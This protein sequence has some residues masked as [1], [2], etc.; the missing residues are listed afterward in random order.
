MPPATP[1]T[2]EATVPR[3]STPM[4]VIAS[5]VPV[6][7][8]SDARWG[9]TVGELIPHLS[10]RRGPVITHAPAI[11]QGALVHTDL[12]VH[13]LPGRVRPTTQAAVGAGTVEA[14]GLLHP[15]LVVL[16]CNGFDPSGFTTPD[17]DEA[18]VKAAMARCAARRVVLADSSKAGTRHLVTF[19][20]TAGINALVTDDHLPAELA[21]ELEEAGIEVLTA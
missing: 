6:G 14:V 2:A 13:V 7:G 18:A 12:E 1:E 10:G 4:I 19:A 5:A 11:A 16:G 20:T 9:T 15:E 21:A 3:V 8:S 17:P